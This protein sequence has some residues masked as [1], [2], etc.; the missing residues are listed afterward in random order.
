MEKPF[1]RIFR[2]VALAAALAL[3]ACKPSGFSE[4]EKRIIGQLRLSELAKLQPDPTNRH[5]DEPLAAAF[6]AT[7]FFDT[8]LSS[9]GVVSCATCHQI[10]NQFQDGLPLARAIGITDRR[11]MPLADVAHGPWFFWDGRRDSLWAQALVPL[12]EAREHGGNRTAYAR[13]MAERYR[14]RY[15]RIFGPLPDFSGLPENAS[16]LGTEAERAVWTAMGEAERDAV[17][18]VF[19]N[20]GKAIAAFE[21]T[22]A[23][24]ETRF[25]RFA[26]AVVAGREPEGDAR[27]SA[28]EIEGLKLFIGKANCIDCHNGPRFTDDHF[29][30]TGVPPV[31]GLPDDRGRAQAV[32]ELVG[33]P[34]NCLG[35]YSDAG[36]EACEE[37]RF[38][39]R[40]GAELERAFKTPS[41]RGAA[42]RPPYMHSGQIATLEEVVDH[43]SRAPE[44]A[45]GQ[46]E[47]G[48]VIFTDRGKAALIAFL[49]TLDPG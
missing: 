49:K 46:S 38:M 17:D 24:G 15:E 25:D 27:F 34:F 7:L 20:I 48:G 18:R 4:E 35:K 19:S 10:D 6:G 9:D 5:A 43:Y 28:L 37:L 36:P 14:E 29:H 31:E 2:L 44:A 41:L 30:N 13:M 26:E 39:R 8:R 12:E 3:G 40:D 11:T 42:A 32:A 33:D 16:P 21:R 22:I 47:I 45:S 1:R 23:H